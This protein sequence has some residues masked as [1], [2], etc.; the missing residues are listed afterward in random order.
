MASDLHVVEV[1]LWGQQVGAVAALRGKPGFFEFQYSADFAR[2]GLE[3]SPLQMPLSPRRRYSF[4]GLPQD[5]YFGLPGL[6]ADAL[7]DR[8]GNALINEYL[9]RRGIAPS[10]ITS[11]QRLVYVGRRAMGALEFEPAVRDRDSAQAAAP[12]QMASLVEDAR[13][14]L[15]GEFSEVAQDIIDVGSSAG[16]ARAKAVI[17][18]NAESNSIVSGQF[19]L[20]A[21]YEHWLLK[22]DGVGDDGQLGAAAGFGRIEYAHYLMAIA[23]GIEM[24]ECRLLEEGG[25]AHFMTRRFDRVGNR[26]LHVHSLCGLQHLDFNT[27][28][29][30]GYEQFFRTILSMNLGAA[31]M[32]QA[33]LR[34]VFNVM[35]RNCDDHTKNLAFL[36]DESGTWSLAPAYDLCFAHN[37]APGKWTRQHQMLVA[38]K[39]EGIT[40]ADLVQVGDQFGIR[41]PAHHIDRL[42]D[43]FAR[44]PACAQQAGVPLTEA[45]RIAGL[46][47]RLTPGP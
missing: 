47:Q 39:G 21:G 14:A 3:L 37:P 11:L 12:L 8:F 34:C 43:V 13:R 1:R 33:W 20:P 31:A 40:R 10:G 15:R 35:A 25:R 19:E 26:K 42:A 28:Y 44:W 18:W 38:G 4:P 29:V 16:G 30:H 41:Q 6:L 46:Q 23:C 5:T 2:S 7:P 9:T 24:S 36:M 32:E 27:P 22:F 45:T 17:G